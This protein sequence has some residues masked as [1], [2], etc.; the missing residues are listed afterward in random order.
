MDVPQLVFMKPDG[1]ALDKSLMFAAR[2]AETE[3]EE[4]AN[5]VTMVSVM[6]MDVTLAVQRLSLDGH[7]LADLHLLP[8][9]VS[10]L[11]E[12]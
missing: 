5:Y 7:A 4:E 2:S 8:M 12:I 10:Q 1:A 9:S 3:F 11:A 6:Q